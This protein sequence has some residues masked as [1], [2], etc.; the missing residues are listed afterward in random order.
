MLCQ[1]NVSDETRNFAQR[2][3]AELIKEE[4]LKEVE[5]DIRIQEKL[6]IYLERYF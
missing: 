1:S 6:D 3:D 5:A 4:K 2:H